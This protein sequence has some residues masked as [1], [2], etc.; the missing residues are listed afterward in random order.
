M[1]IVKRI[2][3]TLMLPVGM[4][5]IMMILCFANGK[6][7]FGSLAMWKTLSVD[8]AVSITC[9]LGIGLQFKSGRFDFSGGAIMLVAGIIAGNVAKGAGNNLLLMVVLCMVCCLI[10]SL[11]VALLYVYG[12]LPII[13]ATIG[14]AMLYEAITC[15]LY[16]GTGINLVSN[17]TLRSISTFPVVLIPLALG[18]GIYAF[19]SYATTT[20]KQ[21]VLLSNNQQS[22]VNIGINENKN[23]IISYIYSGLI[24]GIATVIWLPKAMHGAS[25][26]SLAT[27]GELFSNILPV[28]IGLMLVN[29]CGDTIGTIMGS[30]TLCLLNYGLKAVLSNETGAA[31]ATVVTGIFILALNVVSAQGMNWINMIKQSFRRKES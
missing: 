22:A 16:N 25:F 27:V 31:V 19:Y 23:I 6:M 26:T 5:I 9:A 21:A 4:Y 18:I 29:F 14:M 28:F 10:L 1:K 30:I 12:R 20:G 24:F 11:A 15:L 13:I 2:A 8:I 17:M 3:G 7:F